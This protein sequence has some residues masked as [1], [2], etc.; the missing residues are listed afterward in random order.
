MKTTT[1]AR[2]LDVNFFPD[3][4]VGWGL[5]T[6]INETRGPHGRGMNSLTWAGFFNT[7][8]WL[9]STRHIAA[10]I[11]MQVL[12]FVDKQAVAVYGAYEKAIC[13]TVDAD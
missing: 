9:D 7:Y 12:P 3:I 1:P 4:P 6:M 13:E 11:L 10:V 5:A 2:S 8:Y